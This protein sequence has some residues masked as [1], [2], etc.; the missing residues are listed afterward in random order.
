MVRTMEEVR[1]R[2]AD[3]TRYSRDVLGFGSEVLGVHLPEGW[4]PGHEDKHKEHPLTEEYLRK[5]AKSY[6]DFAFEKAMDH[7]GISASRSVM[8]LREW[9]WL[10]GLDE[11]VAFC[12]DDNN[13]T[14]Y[15]VPILK[16]VA[17]ALE[18]PL[19]D[20]IAAWEDGSA[21]TPDCQEGCG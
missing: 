14:N 7:R 9:M 15:G 21:C 10:L 13:Y 6:L 3:A 17:A 19:P 16:R 20:M 1:A 4:K 8:K 18:V 2:Y 12:D 11:V 5:A